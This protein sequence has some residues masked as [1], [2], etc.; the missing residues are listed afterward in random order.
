MKTEDLE[1]FN[2]LCNDAK[3]IYFTSISK[4]S[5]KELSYAVAYVIA[6]EIK[7]QMGPIADEVRRKSAKGLSNHRTYE[8]FIRHKFSFPNIDLD[9]LLAKQ[10]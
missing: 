9:D 5:G 4:K 7:H 1:K 10:K 6:N 8:N 3:W 2:A